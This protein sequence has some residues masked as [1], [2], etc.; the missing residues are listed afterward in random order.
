MREHAL[1][2]VVRCSEAG[3][4]ECVSLLVLHNA[5]R[6]FEAGNCLFCVEDLRAEEE[7]CSDIEKF[8]L[9][10]LFLHL[11]QA[12]TLNNTFSRSQQARELQNEHEH[13]RETG[14]RTAEPALHLRSQVLSS[15][16][17]GGQGHGGGGG[18]A[19]FEGRGPRRFGYL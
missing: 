16:G 12:N 2:T 9:F 4:C 6:C 7:I 3:N 11:L 13:E 10:C 8:C 5:V 17:R 18:A 19:T 15:S 1:C 14:G